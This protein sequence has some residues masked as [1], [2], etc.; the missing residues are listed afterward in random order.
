MADLVTSQLILDGERLVIYK[1]TNIS[2]GTGESD[3]I[4]IDVSTLNHQGGPAQSGMP[5]NGLKLNKVIAST[6][7]LSVQMLWDATTATLAW[8]APADS[9]YSIDLSLFGGIPNNAGTGR[10]GDLAFT[11]VGASSGDMYSIVVE[12]IKTYGYAP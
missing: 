8:M 11:T 12:C 10:T 1:F 3:V 7:G 2:D 9:Q 4:K 6:S 5:C